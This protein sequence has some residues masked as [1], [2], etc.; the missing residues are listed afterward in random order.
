VV[1]DLVFLVRTQRGPLLSRCARKDR[2]LILTPED[3][4]L[5]PEVLEHPVEDP[6]P[7]PLIGRPVWSARRYK[8]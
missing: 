7:G 1:P 2:F 8:R 4:S 3:P 6:G 5:V